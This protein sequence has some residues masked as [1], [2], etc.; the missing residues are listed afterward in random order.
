MAVVNVG[1]VLSGECVDA[2]GQ[3]VR[4]PSGSDGTFQMAPSPNVL[5]GLVT[6]N[7]GKDAFVSALLSGGL[8]PCDLD[9]FARQGYPLSLSI[10]PAYIAI[11]VEIGVSGG[12]SSSGSADVSLNG[13]PLVTLSASGAPASGDGSL[14]SEVIPVDDMGL[15]FFSSTGIL[16]DPDAFFA[17]AV[18]VFTIDQSN[19]LGLGL[20]TTQNVFIEVFRVKRQ[21]GE[22]VLGDLVKDVT[23]D[24]QPDNT[25]ESVAPAGPFTASWEARY[26]R[27]G[28]QD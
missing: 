20:G 25:L 28:H 15:I 6:S 10:R 14:F 12:I 21:A 13:T 26:Y 27:D 1:E 17:S 8:A 16:L 9:T 19:S 5:T 22:W 3:V 2:T 24:D 4:L 11:Y 18:N 7:S 23:G